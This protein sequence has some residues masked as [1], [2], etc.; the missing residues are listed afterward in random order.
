VALA[1]I[2]PTPKELSEP[3]EHF[4]TT[5][6]GNGLPDVVDFGGFGIGEHEPELTGGADSVRL[7][8]AHLQVVGAAWW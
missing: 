6:L 1:A 2:K 7:H 3:L 5:I 8:R 4:A